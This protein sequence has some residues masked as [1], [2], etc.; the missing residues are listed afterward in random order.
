MPTSDR[1]WISTCWSTNWQIRGRHF[2]RSNDRKNISGSK[3][4]LRSELSKG[5]CFIL[6]R[7]LV[8]CLLFIYLLFSALSCKLNPL[9][10]FFFF[11]GSALIP[12]NR[13][14]LF[15]QYLT[16]RAKHKISKHLSL[17]ERENGFRV[18]HAVCVCVCVCF[19]LM[20]S[21]VM[22]HKRSPP[23]TWIENH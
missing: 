12:W 11:F 14:R 22:W 19:Q 2:F 13:E 17:S 6:A 18:L 3:A 9:F 1:I 15:P 8:V 16:A 5:T 23:S 4:T 7:D 20:V 10:F 21:T